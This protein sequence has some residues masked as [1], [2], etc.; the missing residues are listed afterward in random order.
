MKRTLLLD[1]DYTLFCENIPRPYL[2]VFILRHLERFNIY[3]YTAAN[4]KRITEVCRILYHQLNIDRS[5]ITTL[6]R[7]SLSR[8]NCPMINYKKKDGSY[9]EI[10]CLKKAAEQLNIPF[11]SIILLDD[12]PMYD[13]PDKDKII[14]AEGFYGNLDDIYLNIL[15]IQ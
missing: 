7:F 4:Q 1:I 8:D 13:H 6:N 11:K 10:K 9:I 15:E 5:I 12:A 2:K 3:F 14:Q